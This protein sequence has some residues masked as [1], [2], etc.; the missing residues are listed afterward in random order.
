M[1]I[2]CI[3]TFQLEVENHRLPSRSLQ[4]KWAL[5]VL[6]TCSLVIQVIDTPITGELEILKGEFLFEFQTLLQTLFR[7]FIAFSTDR[8]FLFHFDHRVHVE[9]RWDLLVSLL[10][11]Q[12][13]ASLFFSLLFV[14]Y[15][16]H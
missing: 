7:T 6:L 15:T 4:L 12:W 2:L 10:V 5:I 13:Y 9:K 14:F 8:I 16:Y 11:E 1:E 3:Y